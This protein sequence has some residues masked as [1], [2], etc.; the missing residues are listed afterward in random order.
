MRVPLIAANWKMNKDVGEALRFI[1]DLA[2]RVADVE[3]TEIVIAAPFTALEP[4]K[5]A[6]AGTPLKLAAQNVS[7][8]PRGAFTGEISVQM[9]LD[10]GCRYVIVGHSERRALFGETSEWVARKAQAAHEGG[11]R[12]IVCFGETLEERDAGRTIAVVGEQVE[13][14]LERI[15]AAGAAELVLAYEPV[16]AIGTGRNATPE[17]AQEVHGFVREQLGKRFG[18]AAASIRILYGGSVKPGNI[19]GL[20]EQP[21]IDGALVGGAS[22]DPASL[23]AIIRFDNPPEE[24]TP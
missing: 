1:E 3:G 23:F 4:L 2:P 9:L 22:L 7:P 20:M 10:V 6:V 18:D 13:R 21:D 14:S 8:E 16:W 19:F 11:L 24:A 15:Q 5:G 12:P 17:Q